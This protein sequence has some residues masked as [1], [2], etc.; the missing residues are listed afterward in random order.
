MVGAGIDDIGVAGIHGDGIDVLQ[1]RISRRRDALPVSPGVPRA[2]YSTAG[3]RDQNIR[4]PR[5]KL[6]SP[7]LF[8][9]QSELTPCSPGILAPENTT[10]FP[11]FLV[12]HGGIHEIRLT[13]ASHQP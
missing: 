6:Q 4:P 9:Y 8:F 11:R 3:S 10:A 5:G 12:P 1:F 2:K 13:G 7:H